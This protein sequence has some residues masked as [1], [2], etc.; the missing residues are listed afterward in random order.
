MAK[1]CSVEGC[2]KAS[3]ARGLCSTHYSRVRRN[4]TLEKIR[5]RGICSID[6]C[7]KPHYG[8]GYCN[9]HY[10]RWR[11]YGD[12]L[13]GEPIRG[14]KWN[15]GS[16]YVMLHMPNHPNAQ[17]GGALPEHVLIM[18]EILGRPLR[19]DETVHHVNGVR[20]DNRP[21]NLELWASNHPPGQRISDLVGWAQELLCEYDPQYEIVQMFAAGSYG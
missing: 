18:S 21:E 10:A 19:G 8:H 9:M 17:A 11:K 16:G 15:N 5:K 1:T 13:V 4:G 6:D 2:E 14:R 7:K 20:D 3:W 12:P